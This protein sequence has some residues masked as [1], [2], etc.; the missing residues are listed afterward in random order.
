MKPNKQN[1]ND[2]LNKALEY[3]AVLIVGGVIGY[4]LGI[5]GCLP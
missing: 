1:Y 4:W 3:I 2:K 5:K